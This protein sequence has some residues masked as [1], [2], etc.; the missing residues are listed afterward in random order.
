MSVNTHDATEQDSDQITEQTA[1]RRDA[2][3]LGAAAGI[4]LAAGSAGAGTAAA[5]EQVNFGASIAH[6]PLIDGSYTVDTHR[7]GMGEMQYVDDSGDVAWLIDDGV[8]LASRDDEGGP[9]NPVQIRA[10]KIDADEYRA[11]PR[12]ETFED[13]DG[14]TQDLNVVDAQHW[15][16]DA[17]GSAGSLTVETVDAPSGGDALRVAAD[18]QADGDVAVATFDDVAIDEG[19]L[20]KYLQAIANVDALDAGATVDVVVADSAGSEVRATI[21]AD[22][23]A[24]ADTTIATATGA[25]QVYQRQIG[26]LVDDLDTL[27]ELRVEVADADADVTF[28]A[29]NVEREDNW[30]FGR[31]ERLNADDEVETETRTEPS[32]Y[33]GITSLDTV[34][35]PIGGSRMRD[36]HY[37]VELRASELPQAQTLIRESDV[38][39]SRYDRPNRLEVAH[40]FEAPTAYDLSADL[41]ALRDVVQM[42]SSRYLSVQVE[43]AASGVETWDDVDDLDMTDRSSQYDSVDAERE[44]S[45]AVSSASQAVIYYDLNLDDSEVDHY[46]SAAGG[47]ALAGGSGGGSGLRSVLFGGALGL[48]AWIANRV[49]KARN[50][51]N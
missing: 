21:D 4:A 29:L 28:P 44:L 26:D 34:E 8:V 17:S 25:G 38:D 40:V 2:L 5:S 3:R 1:T 33:F 35:S 9:H 27:V 11:F 50:A 41:D 23:D 18:G 31:Y 51:V 6:D 47:G 10:D 20:R 42:A 24:G 48:V 32:G 37:D 46:L 7:E 43:P 30:S 49:R 16:V 13:A 15:D 12:G 19:E 14:E 22:A 39:E 45:T 36:I